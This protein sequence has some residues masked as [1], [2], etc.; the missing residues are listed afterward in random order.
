MAA[1]LLVDPYRLSELQAR[2][3]R[4]DPGA[5]LRIGNGLPAR[6]VH[7]L[8]RFGYTE[9]DPRTWLAPSETVSSRNAP[10]ARFPTF[11]WTSF[12]TW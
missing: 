8:H 9:A 5:A 1:C 3:L 6:L 4:I 11:T 12:V 10:S 2:R 7:E